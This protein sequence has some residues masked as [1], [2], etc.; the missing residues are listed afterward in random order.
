M[1]FSN[2][3]RVITNGLVS[4]LDAAD[5]NSYPGSG[6]NWRDVV[7]T[8]RNFVLTNGPTFNSTNGGTIVF[9]GVDDYAVYNDDIQTSLVTVS[10]WVY[11][12]ASTTNQALFNR[13]NTAWV[14]AQINGTI[15]IFVS[16]VGSFIDTG[17]TVP[18]NEWTNIVFTYSGTGLSGSQ[19]LYINGTSVFS[20]ASGSGNLPSRIRGATFTIGYYIGNVSYWGGRISQM[21]IYS[22]ALS[23]SEVLQNYNTQKSRFGL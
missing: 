10:A 15:Q 11:K 7:G 16:T 23:A 18:L 22:R 13:A 3:P 9:D 14:L 4:S 20:S 2:G 5:T 6:T 17:Y 1:A 21:Q 8:F 12:T 19:I